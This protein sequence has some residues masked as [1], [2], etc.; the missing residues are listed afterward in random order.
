M[1]SGRHALVTGGGREI[2]R[3]VAV[4]LTA[5]APGSPLGLTS[6]HCKRWSTRAMPRAIVWPTWSTKS[7]CARRHQPSRDGRGAIDILVAM[8][9]VPKGGLRGEP[10]P[11]NS[12]ACLRSMCWEWCTRARG[13]GADEHAGGFGRIV[14]VASTARAERLSVTQRLLRCQ[15]RRDR[16]GA[17]AGARDGE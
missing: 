7:R 9:V 17:G 15:T 8:Q 5:S 11:I 6:G 13:G 12:A 14:A 3:A 2:G 4:A 10:M 16:L 1:L